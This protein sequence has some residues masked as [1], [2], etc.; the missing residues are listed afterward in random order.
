MAYTDYTGLTKFC[1]AVRTYVDNCFY[2]V[3]TIDGYILRL[4][5]SKTYAEQETP[6]YTLYTSD[7]C[8]PDVDPSELEIDCYNTKPRT[9]D[10][11]FTNCRIMVSVTIDEDT[12]YLFTDET[13]FKQG[14]DELYDT[15]ACLYPDGPEAHHKEDSAPQNHDIC[16]TTCIQMVYVTINDSQ[17]EVVYG[18]PY[19]EQ[20]YNELYTQNTYTGETPDE[21]LIPEGTTPS[22]GDTLWTYCDPEQPVG[23]RVIMLNIN[24]PNTYTD[25]TTDGTGTIDVT[26]SLG[27]QFSFGI[28]GAIAIAVTGWT[29][30]TT[31]TLDGTEYTY[32][33][34]N[35]ISIPKGALSA[36]C[37]TIE[38][39]TEECEI[40][41]ALGATSSGRKPTLNVDGNAQTASS[42]TATSKQYY[43]YVFTKPV[44]TSSTAYLYLN[45]TG[46]IP[47]IKIKY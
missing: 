16:Y 31:W 30:E 7:V 40:R 6:Y 3:V 44:S 18:T 43:E 41:L 23:N 47:M 32:T 15:N 1:Q 34:A 10:I 38:T 29:G 2:A 45:N 26:D 4:D 11:L 24:E 14:Y 5:K 8:Q 12:V 9:G 19:D 37:I 36:K 27:N 21:Y 25:N 28:S 13:Y 22:D 42:G 46:F 33:P 35:A 39:G 20:G 17:T